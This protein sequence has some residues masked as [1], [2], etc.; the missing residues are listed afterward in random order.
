MHTMVRSWISGTGAKQ[1]GSL[2]ENSGSWDDN[3]Y[4]FEQLDGDSSRF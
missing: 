1:T 2:A 4:T 3:K